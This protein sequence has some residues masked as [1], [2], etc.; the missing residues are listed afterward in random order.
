VGKID[1]HIGGV[2]A[3]KRTSAG[4]SREQLAALAQC[5]SLEI[6]AIEVMKARARPQL[7]VAIADVLGL[8]IADFFVGFERSAGETTESDSIDSSN[9]VQFRG[10]S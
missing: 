6:V 7:L 1:V 3:S 9:V 8:K 4:L 10:R 5:S 2:V